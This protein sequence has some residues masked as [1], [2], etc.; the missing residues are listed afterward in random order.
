MIFE[1]KT[2]GYPSWNRTESFFIC[3]GSIGLFLV[4]SSAENVKY[5]TSLQWNLFL[6]MTYMN[7]IYHNS[8]E[9]RSIKFRFFLNN[10]QSSSKHSDV[11]YKIRMSFIYGCN[12]PGYPPQNIDFY[13]KKTAKWN[14]DEDSRWS[15]LIHKRHA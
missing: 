6:R 7:S 8:T 2:G 13:V 1:E 4:K 11:K 9:N 12:L 15:S 3:H 14:M 10:R 5:L